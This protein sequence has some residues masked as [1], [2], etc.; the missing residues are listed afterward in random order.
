MRRPYDN[1]ATT[2]SIGPTLRTMTGPERP[3]S[4]EQPRS[5]RSAAGA[6]LRAATPRRAH[7]SFDPPP[8]RPDPVGIIEAQGASRL[9]ALLPIRY[10]RM[11]ASPLA[12]L[13]G[14]AAIMA[15]DLARTPATGLRAQSGGD[16]HLA[17]FGS[18]PTPAGVIFDINDFDETLP[19]PFEWDVKRLAASLVLAARQNA[20]S[21]NAARSIVSRAVQAYRHEI[22]AAARL[23]PVDAW[24]VRIDVE[25]AIHAI[26]AHK[27]RTRARRMLHEGADG[28]LQLKLVDG[29]RLRDHPPLVFHIPEHEDQ[30]RAAFG[31]YIA[32]LPVERRV[33]LE[34]Y[35]LGDVAF[36]V[37]GIGSVGTFCAI[38][39]FT[40]ADND[41]LLLQIKEA[42]HSVL[43]P[44]AGPS[45]FLDQGE[46]VVS[47]Q[48]LMQAASDPFLGATVMPDGKQLYVRQLKN[49]RLAA[50]ATELQ[51][52]DLPAYASLCGR[53]L[54]RAHARSVDAATLAGYLGRGHGFAEAIAR[55]G[56]HYAD[57]T[58][59]DFQTFN[60]AIRAGR[61]RTAAAPP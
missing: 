52:I 38:G 45:I 41:I 11:S 15:A 24:S 50:I 12:F 5:D 40:T 7:A 19:A 3:S 36:K 33:L 44:H 48:R 14:A 55:F 28:A 4:A 57:Q 43:A 32:A 53:T 27:A 30:V 35:R 23:A 13:R 2:G 8:D 9:A 61:I 58:E 10:A 46:R 20:L 29:S 31:L 39:L 17:N 34:R 16:C 59:R 60:D 37:V 51:A 18:Y 56:E 54:G 22:A 42:R 25:Q 26:D 49:A 6:A 47:G 1:R 21:G